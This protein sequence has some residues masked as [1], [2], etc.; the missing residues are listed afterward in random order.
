MASGG[1]VGADAMKWP[2]LTAKRVLA[3][4]MALFLA[5]SLAAGQAALVDLSPNPT[6]RTTTGDVKNTTDTN[7]AA[8]PSPN[9]IRPRNRTVTVNC[10]TLAARQLT[11]G[12]RSS[13]NARNMSRPALPANHSAATLRNSTISTPRVGS[14]T[15]NSTAPPPETRRAVPASVRETCRLIEQYSLPE[16]VIEMAPNRTATDAGPATDG[17]ANSVAAYSNTSDRAQAQLALARDLRDILT[18]DSRS[19]REATFAAADLALAER[20]ELAASD[21]PNVSVQ[22]QLATQQTKLRGARDLLAT[23]E[24]DSPDEA[25]SLSRTT[26]LSETAFTVQVARMQTETHPTDP[27]EVMLSTPSSADYDTPVAATVAILELHD[28][29][30]TDAQAAEL[31]ALGT[32]PVSTRQELTDVLNAYLVYYRTVQASNGTDVQRVRTAQLQ[33]LEAAADLEAALNDANESE[34]VVSASQELVQ[35]TVQIGGVVSI[36]LSTSHNTY[37]EDYKLQI[38]AGGH[39]TYNNNAGGANASGKSTDVAALIDLRGADTYNGRNG[40]GQYVVTNES[41]SVEHDRLSLPKKG[42]AAGFLLD[43]GTRDDTYNAEA[44]GS[45]GGGR[46]GI[47]FLADAGGDDT[48]NGNGKATNGAGSENGTGFLL[49]AGLG[50][51]TYDAGD[52]GV[53]NGGARAGRGFLFDVGGQDTYVGW[54]GGAKGQVLNNYLPDRSRLCRNDLAENTSTDKSCKRL[55]EFVPIPNPR[56]VSGGLL[57]DGGGTDTYDGVNSDRFSSSN[58]GAA[59][60]G[61]GFLLDAGTGDDTYDGKNGGASLGGA[62]GFLLDTG[63]NDGYLATHHT[64]NGAGR[65][66]GLGFLMDGG[67]G[68]DTYNATTGNGPSGPRGDHI[69]AGSLG[70]N[71]GGWAHG[72]GFLVDAGGNDSYIAGSVGTNGGATGGD[73]DQPPGPPSPRNPS[74]GFLLDAGGD[75]R[76]TAGGAGVNGGA[77]R[78]VGLLYDNN[79]RDHYTDK[80]LRCIDCSDIPK[81]AVGAQIDRG[82]GDENATRRTGPSEV[83]V[84]DDSVGTADADCSDASY[85]TIQSA[86]DAAEYG[87]TVRVC[88]GTYPGNVTIDTANVTLRAAEPGQVIL[89]GEH[90][91]SFGVALVARRT[92][93]TGFTAKNFTKTLAFGPVPQPEKA[94]FLAIGPQIT[95]SNNVIKDSGF[96]VIAAGLYTGSFL[97]DSPLNEGEE[98]SVIHNNTVTNTSLGFSVVGTGNVRISNN[99][100]R[101]SPRGIYLGNARQISVHEN[102]VSG[103]AIPAGTEQRGISSVRSSD[104]TMTDNTITGFTAPANRTRPSSALSDGIGIEIRTPAES[105]GEKTHTLR[106]NTMAS[107]TYNLHVTS[108][109]RSAYEHLTIGPSNTVNG[110]PVLYLVGATNMVIGPDS[111]G[112]LPTDVLAELTT[113]R[114]TIPTTDTLETPG[115]VACVSCTD[116][117][118]RDLELAHNGQGV[119]VAKSSGIHVDNVTVHD[120]IQGISVQGSPSNTEVTQSM[121]TESF[122]GIVVRHKCGDTADLLPLI[123][124]RFGRL[125]GDNTETCAIPSVRLAN[126][127]ITQAG[128]RGVD[129]RSRGIDATGTGVTVRGNTITDSFGQGIG[130]TRVAPP[131]TITSPGPV[132]LGGLF[133]DTVTDLIALD[134]T[135]SI[136][137]SSVIGNTIVNAS[138]GVRMGGTQGALV[139]DNTISDVAVGFL[140]GHNDDLMY[141]NNRVRNASIGMYAHQSNTDLTARNN[142]FR[143]VRWGLDVRLR[144]F[145]ASASHDFGTTNTVNGERILW[146]HDAVNRTID[147]S[148]ANM[149]VCVNCDDV[150]V[151]DGALGNNGHGIVYWESTGSN[152]TNVTVEDTLRTGVLIRGGQNLTVR[153]TTIVDSTWPIY[154]MPNPESDQ[155]GGDGGALLPT[156]LSRTVQFSSQ[157]PRSV[158]IINNRVT[159]D[160]AKWPTGQHRPRRFMQPDLWGHYGIF[161]FNPTVATVTG[162]NVTKNRWGIT[163]WRGD[164]SE[165]RIA[166]NTIRHSQQQ[167]GMGRSGGNSHLGGPVA[168]ML[169]IRVKATGQPNGSIVIRNN[170]LRAGTSPIGTQ[171]FLFGITIK[172]KEV[173]S[174]LVADNRVQGYQQGVRVATKSNNSMVSIRRNRL[175]GSKTASVFVTGPT[176]GEAAE[177]HQNLLNPLRFGYGVKHSMGGGGGG[178]MGVGGG[179]GSGGGQTATHQQP[180]DA[181]CNRWAAPS[182][183]SSRRHTV[184]DPMT[185]APADGNGSIVSQGHMHGRSNVHFHP[186][187]GESPRLSCA[188][189]V[190]GTATPTPTPG[191]TRTPWPTAESGDGPGAGSGDNGTGPGDNGTGPGTGTAT[192]AGGGEGT[193]TATARVAA[194]STPTGTPPPTATP[195]IVPG[196]GVG[197]WLVAFALLVAVLAARRRD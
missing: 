94:A 47:G 53:S 21:H 173:P 136:A 48:Y 117:T 160:D 22:H 134:N 35:P 110:E 154:T 25:H 188:K 153:N 130:M 72:H 106:N 109:R 178:H 38:D 64:T 16:W 24:T 127:T 122:K 26:R 17:A 139:R 39:D 29:E 182:G 4:G 62:S 61:A 46:R 141:R 71:G 116:V 80:R 42:I 159:V 148:D 146:L 120:T 10:S 95:V 156:D 5:L 9:A 69:G 121:V 28:V 112:E 33:L 6:D 194:T 149:V 102:T 107:N 23:A 75:D 12:A 164:V 197:V 92:A 19:R 152:V 76:Y 191:P 190:V 163:H 172:G 13:L 41:L 66:R 184:V 171:N 104:I 113:N 70:T 56:R 155:F 177:I 170:K 179:N 59:F 166:N 36:D 81:G 126:N 1:G 99:I 135:L 87:D 67:L 18:A 78:A 181:T 77:S 157:T 123:S 138:A 31:Q 175:T 49:D 55:T 150:T 97:A 43:A 100:I 20:K 144:Y 193:S 79:G 7:P 60:G 91:R 103:Q 74:T 105:G 140:G 30:L 183:P 187:I 2:A 167:Q 89:D 192:A 63:G 8:P 15:G 147:A 174:T 52:E 98:V 54:N 151:Q 82:R 32:L 176:P 3:V 50:R 115:Y 88:T 114:A 11:P 119:L 185:G 101:E 131:A 189:A 133:P 125:F 161:L 132:E 57:I 73:G 58:G 143:A 40:G 34:S 124:S 93:V 169:G 86:V 83:L 162:N 145:A 85:Q 195:E 142:S 90:K 196:F 180:V 51:D 37:T 186:W 45:N 68:D 129:G 168:Q 27:S 137:N 165:L 84:V 14:G 96:G 158:R 44:H 108:G 111:T 65:G 118:V 128:L